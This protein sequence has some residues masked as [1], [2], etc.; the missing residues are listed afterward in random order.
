MGKPKPS[1]EE[2]QQESA[3]DGDASESV[4]SLLLEEAQDVFIS[5]VLPRLRPVDRTVLARVNRAASTAVGPSIRA[6]PLV[7]DA[8]C[9]TIARLAWAK[10]NGAPWNGLLVCAL[11]RKG[12]VEVLEWAWDAWVGLHSLPGARLATWTTLAVI[13][14]LSRPGV[15]DCLFFWPPQKLIF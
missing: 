3:V 4:L 13:N 1:E 10:A 5:E 8:F 7:V 2:Q 9:D 15:S 12:K 6:A 14:G 11:A